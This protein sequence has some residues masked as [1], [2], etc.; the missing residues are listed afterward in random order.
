[1][2]VEPIQEFYKPP[3]VCLHLKDVTLKL[4]LS[5]KY[6]KVPIE[7]DIETHQNWQLLDQSLQA[8][9]TVSIG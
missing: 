6:V 1:M 2:V 9:V 8:Q 3:E 4:P 5:E 7:Y